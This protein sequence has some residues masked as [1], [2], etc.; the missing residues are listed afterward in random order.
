MELL[1]EEAALHM[2]HVGVDGGASNTRVKR[3]D[4]DGRVRTASL[5]QPASLTLGVKQ[6]WR[7][8]AAALQAVGIGPEAYGKTHVACGLAGT[9][10]AEGRAAFRA[11][12]PAFASLAV[13]SD[14]HAAVVGA[15]SGRPGAVV[16]IGTGIVGN[17]VASDGA[18]RQVGGWGFPVRDE[19][20]GAWLGRLVLAEALRVL[21]GYKL[22][23]TPLHRA[24]IAAVG[25]SIDAIA[26]WTYQAPS[27]RYAS[28]APL[29]L[30]AAKAGD[31]AGSRLMRRAAEEVEQLVTALDPRC[32]LPLCFSGSLASPILDHTNEHLRARIQPSQGDACD[33]ALLLAQRLAVSDL[34]P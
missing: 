17:C 12:G 5:A 8:I 25:P 32:E 13:C 9:R 10:R 21:D 33:G 6:A 11:T 18:A 22:A 3:L 29:V 16:T 20:S 31:P 26:D 27:T 14:G 23:A 24:V 19:A 28:L 1:V 7:H 2:T 4:E 34:A 30:D 15:H